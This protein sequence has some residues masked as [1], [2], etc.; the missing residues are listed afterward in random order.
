MCD[1][2]FAGHVS[3]SPDDSKL[4]SVKLNESY[5]D[6]LL[7]ELKKQ[8]GDSETQYSLQDWVVTAAGLSDL[9]HRVADGLC[10]LGVLQKDSQKILWLFTRRLYPELDSSYEDRIRAEMGAAMFSEKKL[11]DV[12][13]AALI[14]LA[15]Q[16]GVLHSNFAKVEIEQHQKRIDA[17]SNGEILPVDA[18]KAAIEAVQSAVMISTIVAT[19]T[20]A[21]IAATR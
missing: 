6:E 12:R 7:D 15:N 13:L 8:I 2:L 18:T 21:T 9:A 19:T 14:S 1:L 10:D 20:A 17:I 5:G 4:V 11:P 16:T 3:V